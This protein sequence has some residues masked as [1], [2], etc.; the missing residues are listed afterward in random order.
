MS[1]EVNGQKTAVNVL[2]SQIK[3]HWRII[4]QQYETLYSATHITT[5][6]E[7]CLK[8]CNSSRNKRVVETFIKDENN[9]IL[10]SQENLIEGIKEFEEKIR[11]FVADSL[12]SVSQGKSLMMV[13]AK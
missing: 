1:K 12:I 2:L 10:N 3:N 9:T 5:N 7:Q 4:A 11:H 6:N 8:I 13:Y